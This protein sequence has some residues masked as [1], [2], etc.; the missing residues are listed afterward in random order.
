MHS[1]VTAVLLRRT[2]FDALNAD[3]QAQLPASGREPS[4][5]P[6]HKACSMGAYA[7]EL[8]YEFY[9]RNP[10]RYPIELCSFHYLLKSP[11]LTWL[12]SS[13]TMRP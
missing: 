4:S 12:E 8:T 10:F 5:G 13:Q 7:M 1:L 2:G 3:A 6:S 9:W 11:T